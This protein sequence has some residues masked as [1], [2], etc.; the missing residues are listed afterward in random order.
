MYNAEKRFGDEV[1]LELFNL[2]DIDL[3]LGSNQIFATSPA[4]LQNDAQFKS[5][6]KI[7]ISSS[8]PVHWD[9]LSRKAHC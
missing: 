2:S 4:A 6:S 3:V 1:K 9:Q 8:F 7:I 5:D